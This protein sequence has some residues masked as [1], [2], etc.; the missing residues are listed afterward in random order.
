MAKATAVPMRDA[1]SFWGWALWIPAIVCF[2]NLLQNI[3]YVWWARTRPE[4]AQIP[5]GHGVAREAKK[6]D[7]AAATAA[8]GQARNG[9]T[10][11]VTT[12]FTRRTSVLPDWRVLVRVPRFF[13]LV[14]CTQILQAGTVGGFNGLSADIIVETRGSTE[15]LAGYTSAVQ[16]VIPVICAP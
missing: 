3:G 11:T 14:V 12:T 13:W 5:T 15:E 2:F 7:R 4:W 6:Q 8:A 16:Q 10:I 1:S 9:E